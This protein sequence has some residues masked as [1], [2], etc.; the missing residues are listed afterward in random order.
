MIEIVIADDHQIMRAGMA[1]ILNEQNDMKVIAKAKDGQEAVEKALQLRP[2][3][4]V[5]DMD[6][7][8][9]NGLAVIKEI[10][11]K[12]EEIKVLALTT[13]NQQNMLYS[14]IEAGALGFLSK[15]DSGKDL[16]EAVR[17]VYG[18]SPY[19]KA[20]LAKGIFD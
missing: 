14:A 8:Y 4:V 12:N 15:S 10:L 19:L 11:A 9:K 18:G 1:H 20:E 2:D 17:T 7:S 16:I 3:I 6:I 13:D 5:M